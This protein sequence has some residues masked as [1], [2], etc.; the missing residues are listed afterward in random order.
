VKRE[1]HVLGGIFPACALCAVGFPAR[2]QHPRSEW[3]I[4]LVD[5]K[6]GETPGLAQERTG[7]AGKSLIKEHEGT[8]RYLAMDLSGTLPQHRPGRREDDRRPVPPGPARANRKT[9]A[10]FRRL[11]YRTGHPH[12][13]PGLLHPLHYI[14]RHSMETIGPDYLA[15]AGPPPAAF[16]RRGSY[17]P[18]AAAIHPGLALTRHQ[19]R[20]HVL[21]P[22][23]LPLT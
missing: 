6:T 2:R 3:F 21:R 19:P 13:N 14:L 23:G 20:V 15:M 16:P 12:E 1:R 18:G 11:S 4:H 8:L 9:D 10:A 5:L 17:H 22:P 7:A